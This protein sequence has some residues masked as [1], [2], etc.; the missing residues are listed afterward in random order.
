M[1]RSARVVAVVILLTA[2]AAPVTAQ[3]EIALCLRVEAGSEV[4]LTD[5][6]AIQDGISSGQILVSEVV[7]CEGVASPMA[8]ASQIPDTGAWK[9]LH[10]ETD[11]ITG[12]RRVSVYLDA[13]SGVSSLDLPT[14]LL[15]D[16][17]EGELIAWVSWGWDLGPEPIIDVETRIGDGEP[18]TEPWFNEGEHTVYGKSDAAFITS[19]F[20]ESRL[21]VG[22]ATTEAGRVTALFDVTGIEAAVAGVR[23][24]CDW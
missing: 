5:P 7:P 1:S 24:A 2:I 22:V 4:D 9:V 16:C 17:S 11:Q 8:S 15:I 23:E 14:Q 19:L 3:A 6:A 10:D 12:D 20:G 21:A 13:E 18:V